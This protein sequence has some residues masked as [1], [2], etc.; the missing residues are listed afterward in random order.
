[1]HFLFF[2]FFI[3]QSIQQDINKHHVDLEDINKQYKFLM[4]EGYMDSSNDI[5]DKAWECNE[6]WDNLAQRVLCNMGDM[7]T[8]AG[9]WDEYHFLYDELM[10][11]LKDVDA[12]LIQ[13]E[14][15]EDVVNNIK[16]LS[17][18]YFLSIF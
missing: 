18:S 2:L 10:K 4:K 12:R 8:S 3:F 1:M 5:K 14:K 9:K 6:R 16:C 17:V 15:S 11:W 13:V 7:K